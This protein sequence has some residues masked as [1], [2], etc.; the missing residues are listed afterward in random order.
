MSELQTRTADGCRA[1]VR[2]LCQSRERRGWNRAR[3]RFAEGALT[4]LGCC[5]STTPDQRKETQYIT[6][7]ASASS[8]PR[9]SLCITQSLL[10]P[11]SLLLSDPWFNVQYRRPSLSFA[12]STLQYVLPDHKTSPSSLRESFLF[13]PGPGPSLRLPCLR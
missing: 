8:R 3:W 5:P 2:S 11:P 9:P 6:S 10:I 13:S 7:R 4:R 12:S 1:D